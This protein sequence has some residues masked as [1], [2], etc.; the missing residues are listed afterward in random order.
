MAVTAADILIPTGFI[1]PA[2][3]DADITTSLTAWIADGAAAAPAEATEAQQDA[4]SRAWAHYRAFMAKADAVAN[5][6][7]SAT[8][9][10]ALSVSNAKDRVD[11]WTRKAAE[12]LALYE[13]ALGEATPVV[14]AYAGYSPPTR[15]VERTVAW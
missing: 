8:L 1:D 15:S 10:G 12:W 14:V 9:T 5:S 6:P 3:Y 4:V 13:T 11:Y 7:S 2:W